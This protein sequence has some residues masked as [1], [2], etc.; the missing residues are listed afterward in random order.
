[1]LFLFQNRKNKKIKTAHFFVATLPTNLL[2]HDK[3]QRYF[4]S[5]KMKFKGEKKNRLFSLKM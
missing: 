1:M 2:L 3:K 5:L 4:L